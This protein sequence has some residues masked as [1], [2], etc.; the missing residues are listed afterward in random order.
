LQADVTA[1]T[2]EDKAL[3]ERYGLFGPPGIFFNH[4]G[5]EHEQV[6]VIGYVP[7]VKFGAA[8]GLAGL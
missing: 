3:L 6:R 1:N 7:L 5:Q 2:P 4:Q 8:L